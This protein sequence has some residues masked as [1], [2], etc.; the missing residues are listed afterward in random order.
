MRRPAQTGHART[1]RGFAERVLFRLGGPEPAP[2]R[3]T[4]RRIYLLPTGAGLAFGVAL[5]VMLLTSINYNLSLGFGLVFLLGGLG[6]A[7]LHQAFLNLHDLR[8]GPGRCTAVF[9]GDSASFPLCVNNPATR[10]RAALRLRAHGHASALFE[11]G[12][13]AGADVVVACPAPRRGDFAL[14]RTV[15]ETTWPLG[16]IRAWS[17]FVPDLCCLVYPAPE[18]APPPLPGAAGGDADAHG[19]L[20]DGDDDFAGLRAHRAADSPRHVAWK[21]LA[22]GGPVLTKQYAGQAGRAL[23][24]DWS[25]LPAHL[26]VEQRLSRLTAWVLLAEQGGHRYALAL[27]GVDIAPGHGSAHRAHCLAALARHGQPAAGAGRG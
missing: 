26:D 17:V 11:L 3:L 5:L 23:C 27:P 6:V 15:L 13:Q 25:A 8:L 21:V 1:L 12:P 24:L 9:C 14:G 7:S 19:H 10:R 2:I 20:R 22:R 18:A 4:Q 16:L